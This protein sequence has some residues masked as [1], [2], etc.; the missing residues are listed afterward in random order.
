MVR[1]RLC[2]LALLFVTSCFGYCQETPGWYAFR[3]NQEIRVRQLPSLEAK[4]SDP[5]DVLLTALAILFHDQEIC[6][7][8]DSA[9]E[10]SARLA[11][12]SSLKDIAA[13]LQGRHLLSD[14]RPIMITVESVSGI[15]GDISYHIIGILA[16]DRPMLM[17]WSS[18]LYILRGVIFDQT[19]YSDGSSVNRIHK[20]LLLDPR[21]SDSRREVVFNRDSDDW[22]QV[23]GL[24]IVDAHLL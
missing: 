22:N 24:L 7:G 9:L 21:Y 1:L 12:P 17:L 13:R 6:C 18:H 20:L 23:Q 4:S 19:L 15:A 8:K 14:G 3:P 5:S 2:C 11:D 16:D 10:D